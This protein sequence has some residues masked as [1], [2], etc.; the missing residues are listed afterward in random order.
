M[1]GLVLG[2]LERGVLVGD[3][4]TMAVFLFLLVIFAVAMAI[5]GKDN[6]E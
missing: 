2:R 1:A 6:G 4:K 5:E 3:N